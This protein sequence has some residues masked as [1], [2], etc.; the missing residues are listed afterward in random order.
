[1]SLTS[2]GDS[3]TEGAARETIAF[4][5]RL[6]CTRRFCLP[7]ISSLGMGTFGLLWKA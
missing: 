2:R 4:T 5:H 7:L 3:A 6:A 1:M